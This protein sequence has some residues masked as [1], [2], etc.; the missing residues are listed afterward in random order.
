MLVVARGGHRYVL[1]PSQVVEGRDRP[2]LRR[3]PRRGRPLPRGRRVQDREGSRQEGRA[4]RTRRL[5]RRLGLSHRR[6][7]HLRRLRQRLLLAHHPAPR[8][9]HPHRLRLRPGQALP[10]PVRHPPDA[11]D[12]PSDG[13]SL[14]QRRHRRQPV[15]PVGREVPRA[16]PQDLQPPSSTAPSGS[17][18]LSTPPCPRS[19]QSQ[20][21]SSPPHSSRIF[22]SSYPRGAG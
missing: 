20:Y 9:V 15:P 18:R 1:H 2:A 7:H 3:L 11:P 16:A 8:S 21:R 22:S 10:A 5:P 4:T 17:T 19:S 14:G 12:Q 13:P 6:T